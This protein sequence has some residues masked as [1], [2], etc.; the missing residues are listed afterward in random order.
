VPTCGSSTF[1][2]SP[3]H[4]RHACRAGSRVSNTSLPVSCRAR[5]RPLGRA[6]VAGVPGGRVVRAFLGARAREV[7]DLPA[8]S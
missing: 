7:K 5:T 1:R 2:C 8:A 6:S 4:S 3:V